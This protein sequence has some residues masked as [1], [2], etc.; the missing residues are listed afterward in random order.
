MSIHDKLIDTQLII[1][2]LNETIDI[3]ES[4][5]IVNFFDTINLINKNVFLK[6]NELNTLDNRNIILLNFENDTFIPVIN[7]NETY[8]QIIENLY[9][10][11][12]LIIDIEK[13]NIILPDNISYNDMEKYLFQSFE[14]KLK[15]DFINKLPLIIL[16]INLENIID[17]KSTPFIESNIHTSDKRLE[18][19]KKAEKKEFQNLIEADTKCIFYE[20]MKL[21]NKKEKKILNEETEKNKNIERYNKLINKYNIKIPLTFD[22]IIKTDDIPDASYNVD[23]NYTFVATDTLC[24]LNNNDDLNFSSTFSSFKPIKMSNNLNKKKLL[25]LLN[26]NTLKTIVVENTINYE[27]ISTQLTE[28]GFI[29]LITI[30]I[31]NN[32]KGLINNLYN[33]VQFENIDEINKKLII[34]SEYINLHSKLT[35]N[36]LNDEESQ[37][38]NFI[39]INYEIND[40]IED[41]IKFT[42]IF[43]LI[44]NSSIIDLDKTKLGSLYNRLSEYLKKLGLKKKRYK[45][46]YY[47]Y[48]LSKK[49]FSKGFI[50]LEKYDNAILKYKNDNIMEKKNEFN[51][52]FS[53]YDNIPSEFLVHRSHPLTRP[54]VDK[55]PLYLDEINESIEINRI[56]ESVEII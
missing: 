3:I 35:S 51:L 39:N 7:I 56:D 4:D 23:D 37:I 54:I 30:D 50:D 42:D 38:H 36:N 17:N 31:N 12:N 25:I 21:K 55:D 19:L 2:A 16:K 40:N 11:C 46:G 48:G 41:K 44:I 45:D 49:I 8:L 5:K 6:Y 27:I 13:T 33:N 32:D 24:S 9:M 53:T 18:L 20:T 22:K 43:N 29:K 52:K 1:N 14:I 26:Y 47:Y 15:D 10:N 28:F 34:T